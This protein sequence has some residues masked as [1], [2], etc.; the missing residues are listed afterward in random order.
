MIYDAKP[1]KISIIIPAYNEEKRILPTLQSYCYYF[2]S[3]YKS[4]FE[5]IV[6]LNGCRDNTKKVVEDFKKNNPNVVLINIAQPV[7]KGGAVAQGL[8]VAKGDFIAYTDADGSTRS[9]VLDRIITV[10]E[11]TPSLDCVIGSR[12]I[13]GSVVKNKSTTRNILTSGFNFGVNFLFQLDI[14]D[15]QCGAKVVR[16]NLAKKIIPN[17]EI[18]NMAFDVNFLVD[19]KRVGGQILEV[20]IE[21]EDNLDSKVGNKTKTS[22]VMALSVLRLWFMYSPFRIFYFLLKPFSDL[23]WTLL[24]N[25]TERKYRKIDIEY[26][27]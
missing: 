25:E 20:P 4:S 16:K 18:S 5:I 10:L 24:L 13:A 26:H 22:V 8:S 23:L 19:I 11:I 17:L 7:G 12:N 9:E 3:K 1:M 6:V 2:K 21:W 15:T 27:L 14:K